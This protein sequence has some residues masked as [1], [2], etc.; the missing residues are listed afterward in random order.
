MRT[1]RQLSLSPGVSFLYFILFGF[2]LFEQ[3]GIALSLYPIRLLS[4]R[5]DRDCSV[6]LSRSSSQAHDPDGHESLPVAS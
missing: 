2:C 3:I 4:I 6:A 1:P 5:A